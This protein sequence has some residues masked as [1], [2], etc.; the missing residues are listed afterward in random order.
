MIG[1]RKILSAVTSA[2][3]TLT[4]C[5]GALAIGASAESFNDLEY[6]TVDGHI[7]ITGCNKSAVKVDIPDNIQSV[8][9]TIIEA[10]AFRGCTALTQVTIPNTVTSI[11]SNA[12]YQCSELKSVNIPDSITNIGTSAFS[13]TA[14]F[15]AQTDDV[16]YVGNWAVGRRTDATAVSIKNTTVGIADSAFADCGLESV[17]IPSTVTTIGDF[18]FYGNDGMRS[19]AIPYNVKDLGVSAFEK[20]G[21]RTV[22]FTPTSTVAD[23]GDRAFAECTELNGVKIPDSVTHIG[24]S[25]FLNTAQWK[26]QDGPA[27][28]IDT[29]LVYCLDSENLAL[30]VKNGT[31]GIADYAFNNMNFV[32]SATIPSGVKTIGNGAFYG[33]S[34]LSQLSIADTVTTIGDRAFAGTSIPDVVIPES[35]ASIGEAAFSKCDN[36]KEITILNANCAINPSPYTI[37]A[38]TL[39]HVKNGSTAYAYA[40]SFTP[41]RSFDYKVPDSSY[42]AGDVNND[43]KIGLPDAVLIAKH[44]IHPIL[45][46]EQMKVADMNKDGKINLADA[47]AIAK[48]ILQNKG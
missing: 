9:V 48:I 47:V 43:G 27:L 36:L 20:C 32:I 24:S 34:N 12:F 39:M 4:V 8:P 14:M 17:T 46:E 23:I 13:G 21:L 1:L 6:V 38:N 29:W 35:V 37:P 5:A 33:C 42:L 40:K 41:N 30:T 31:K 10:N 3:C 18:A 45:T 26:N 2:V 28:Y 15:G 16:L 7:E 19:V 22:T 25:A 44:I 11:G